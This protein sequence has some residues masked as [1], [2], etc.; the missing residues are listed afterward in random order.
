[1]PE[2]ISNPF[3]ILD[4]CFAAG[5]RFDMLRVDQQEGA[6]FFQHIV[7][8]MPEHPGTLHRNLHDVQAI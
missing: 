4:V 6:P 7:D 3:A 1:M 8:G 5:E 2:E